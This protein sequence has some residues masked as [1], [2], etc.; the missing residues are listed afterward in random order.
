MTGPL[1]TAAFNALK[2]ARQYYDQVVLDCPATVADELLA[3][4][5][6]TSRFQMGPAG[7]T[8]WPL[9][10]AGRAQWIELNPVDPAV[11]Q[12]SARVAAAW[13]HDVSSGVHGRPL[14]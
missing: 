4:R 13:L 1:S 8:V 12:R 10:D 5:M 11:R 14:S 6:I 7:G 9:T 3:A 2:A